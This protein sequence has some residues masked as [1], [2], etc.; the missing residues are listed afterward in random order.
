MGRQTKMNTRTY[1]HSHTLSLSL[2]LSLFSLT[3]LICSEDREFDPEAEEQLR[4]E[5]SVMEAMYEGQCAVS[6]SGDGT[7]FAH[8]ITITF[9]DLAV[10]M[11]LAAPPPS[12]LLSFCVLLCVCVCVCVVSS[13]WTGPA[14]LAVFTSHHRAFWRVCLVLVGDGCFVCACVCA[15]VPVCVLCVCVCVC[16]CASDVT[17]CARQRPSSLFCSRWLQVPRPQAA[18][19]G[20][21]FCCW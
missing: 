7:Q 16:L 2:S 8:T 17:G 18:H 15:Y 20:E 14:I 10:C 3:L 1:T 4:D 19:S 21:G 12:L 9:K 6:H 13:A 5:I 11:L